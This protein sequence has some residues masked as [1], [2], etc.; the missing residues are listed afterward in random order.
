MTCRSASADDWRYPVSRTSAADLW[1]RRN[2][3][4]RSVICLGHGSPL[5]CS[6]R[7]EFLVR[8]PITIP[9]RHEQ[10]GYQQKQQYTGIHLA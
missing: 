8:R 10:A 3:T 7:E 4:Y 6:L 1:S 9:G 2:F 5:L